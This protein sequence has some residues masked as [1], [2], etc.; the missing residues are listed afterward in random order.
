MN[1]ISTT[2]M[3]IICPLTS[4]HCQIYKVFGHSIFADRPEVTAI[5][6]FKYSLGEGTPWNLA[7]ATQP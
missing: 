1:K 2:I 5:F 3:K 6:F 7:A 4:W